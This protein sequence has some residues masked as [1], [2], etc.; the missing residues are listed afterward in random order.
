M[1]KIKCDHHQMK[2][3]FDFIR[4]FS[5]E[6]PSY[7]I[8]Q[9]TMYIVLQNV[10]IMK[11]NLAPWQANLNISSKLTNFGTECTTLQS[12]SNSWILDWSLIQDLVMTTSRDASPKA[13]SSWG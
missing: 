3:N 5:N 13:S 7:P 2:T 12:G 10:F 6:S 4:F 1:V 9:S 8:L 11:N